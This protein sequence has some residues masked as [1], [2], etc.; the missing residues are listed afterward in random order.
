MPTNGSLGER[1]AWW[2]FAASS[3]LT[4][5]GDWRQKLTVREGFPADQKDL[6]SH[7]QELVSTLRAIPGL[8]GTLAMV[9]RL[10]TPQ[11][12]TTQ[13]NALESLLALLPFAA[14]ELKLV[15]ASEG[16]TDYAEIAAEGR[17]ALGDDVEP[18]ELALRVDWRLQHLLLD[19]FQDTS[20]AQYALLGALTRGWTPGDGR[21][22]FLVG[23][24]MQSIYR[25]RQ[26]EVRLFLDVRDHGLPG[27]ELEF[28][29]LRANF[30][31]VPALVA[32]TNAMF[33]RVFPAVDDLISSAISFAVSEPAREGPPADPE[34]V[35]LHASAWDMP[36][37]EANEVVRVVRESLSM[38]VTGTVGILVRSRGHAAHIVVALRQ[39]GIDLAASDLVELGRTALANDLLAI[40]R[41]LVHAG[42]RL[43][44]LTV[45]RAPWCGLSLADLVCLGTVRSERTLYDL[46]VSTVDPATTESLG[47]TPDG[48]LRVARVVSAFTTGLARLGQLPLRDVVE[49]VWV[50]LGGPAVAGPEI[51]LADLI[52]DEIGRHEVGGDCPD[53]LALSKA[54]DRARASLPG[55]DARVQVMTIH[56]AKGLQFDTVILP[57]LGRGIRGDRRAAL[58]WQELAHAGGLDLLLAPVNARGADDD[59]LYELLWNLRHE[60]GLAESDRLLY[61]AVTRARERLHLF[62]QT[63]A[64]AT[65]DTATVSRPA[66][67]SLLDRLWQV[68]GAAWP[69]IACQVPPSAANDRLPA[70]PAAHWRQPVLRRLS[71][72]WQRPKP[73]AGV[74]VPRG[75]T[76]AAR[77]LVVYD[78]ATAWA[79]QA[80]S[81]AHRCLQQIALDGV[82]TYTPDR[83]AAL[84]PRYRQLL[85][86]QGVEAAS[87]DRALDRVVAV[88]TA[89]L[90]DPAGRWLLVAEHSA[91]LNEY[92]VTIADGGRFRQLI[93]DRA[94]VDA[95]GVRWII[96]YKT[97]SHEGG[98]REAF[99]Q[100]GGRT[101]LT[102]AARVPAGLRVAGNQDRA[103]CPVFS[104]PS[105]AADCRSRDLERPRQRQCVRPFGVGGAHHL[106]CL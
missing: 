50:E 72:N 73:P 31:S 55:V 70:D 90:D 102:P 98:D 92:A 82:L 27:I 79:R 87:V 63:K 2:Q 84:R 20:Q 37:Q 7:A 30:R 8:V 12:S 46:A 15:F 3:L 83:I 48:Q 100:L 11:Y 85:L 10:P 33:D 49:G 99:I 75:E 32:W 104:A 14:A 67:G 23:D 68:V 76:P 53:V 56:K 5:K 93:I 64:G 74:Q 41:A 44:W 60:Q 19:E 36:E 25:F 58:L 65:S 106:Q 22:L 16:E 52:L 6:K 42:D 105:P 47:L 45:L 86:S 51:D 71:S 43:A 38:S 81:V 13:W 66:R 28:L 57:G 21:T 95:D 17:A 29:Q 62:G 101:I 69:V 80:G 96:D 18:S 103:N 39:A 77:S 26:A 24:P 54:L 40:T 1:L 61:V 59:P 34:A 4:A 35:T 94:F 91:Q 9:Q 78:W 97:S 88:L 89:A